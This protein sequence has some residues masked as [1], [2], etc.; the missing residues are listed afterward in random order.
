MSVACNPEVKTL[1]AELGV[2]PVL[3]DILNSRG[4]S[5]QH[6][7]IK[8]A[9]ISCARLVAS[10]AVNLDLCSPIIRSNAMAALSRCVAEGALDPA[11][12]FRGL[13]VAA[14][15]GMYN[16]K[17]SVSN[18][19]RDDHFPPAFKLWLLRKYWTPRAELVGPSSAFR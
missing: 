1:Q 10:L 3:V 4:A 8:A 15:A 11:A 14:S 12:G 6:F 13:A 18:T 16:L 19:T 9:K 5:E 17:S 2:V 7:S